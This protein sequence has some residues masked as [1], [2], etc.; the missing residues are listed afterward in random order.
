MYAVVNMAI[1]E[2]IKIGTREQCAEFCRTKNA[3]LPYDVY[4]FSSQRDYM[5]GEETHETRRKMRH[6]MAV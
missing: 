2:V 6:R 4:T 5:T 1:D 3:S